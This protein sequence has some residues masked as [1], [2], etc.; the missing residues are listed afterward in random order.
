MKRGMTLIAKSILRHR[1]ACPGDLS[2]RDIR[3][4]PGQAGA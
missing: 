2:T 3:E 4:Y 1:P